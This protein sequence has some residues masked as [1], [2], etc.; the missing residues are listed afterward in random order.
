MS[1]VWYFS[2]L[3]SSKVEILMCYFNLAAV[4]LLTEAQPGWEERKDE[5]ECQPSVGMTYWEIS[6][7]QAV[8][9]KEH[10]PVSENEFI[11]PEVLEM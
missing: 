10:Y 3:F 7:S 9:E 1:K 2:I 4:W 5:C 8:T 6:R 11:L